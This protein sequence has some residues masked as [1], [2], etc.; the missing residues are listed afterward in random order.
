MKTFIKTLI[1]SFAAVAM[2]F[3][4]VALAAGLNDDP[5]DHYVFEATNKSGTNGA[6]NNWSRTVTAGDNDLIS[7][8]IY[9]HATAGSINDV[10]FKMEDL[11]GREFAAGSQE[12]VNGQVSASNAGTSAG[13]SKI[14]FTDD[15]TLRLYNVS[16]QPNQCT[17]VTCERPF[18][19]S[20][21]SV[22]SSGINVGTIQEGWAN[23][24]NMVVT[25]KA[26]PTVVTPTYDDCTV[27]G[28]TVAHGASRNFYST[29][30]VAYGQT[31]SAF[32]QT[33]TCND[34]TMSGSTSY[35][36]TSCTVG[37]APVFVDPVVDTNNPTN[38]DEDSATLQGDVDFSADVDSGIVFFEW[39]T[40]SSN[41]YNDTSDQA[42]SSDS[43]FSA[44]ITGLNDNTRYYYR[45]V[46]EGDNGQTYYGPIK[47]FTTDA[48]APAGT[49]V[50]IDTRTESSVQ[51]DSARLNGRL[52]SGD[53]NEVWFAFSGTD[54]TPSC[55]SSAQRV[56]VSGTYDSG[57]S[58]SKTVTGLDANEKYYF[59]AC[60][61]D[62][63][64][65]VL[66]GDIEDFTTDEDEPNNP[67]EDDAEVTTFTPSS[68]DEDSAKLNGRVD[69]GDNSD[70]WFAFSRIDSTPACSAGSQRINVSGSYDKNDSFS[71]TVTGLSPNTKY[72]YRACILGDNGDIESG[73]IRSFVTDE[74][75]DGPTVPTPPTV[76]PVT[77][78]RIPSGVTT[79]QATLR[80]FVSGDG[81]G[82]C[83]FQYGTSTG[84]GLTTPAQTVNLDNTGECTSTRFNLQPN[85]T[86]YYRSV[87]V[88]GGQTYYGLRQSFR[89]GSAPVVT[90]PPVVTTPRVPRTP[91]ITTPRIPIVTDNTVTVTVV[92]EVEQVVGGLELT[93]FV[94]SF[95][96][97]RFSDET[98]ADRDEA[99]FYKVLVRNNT[100]EVLEDLTVVDYIPFALELDGQRALNDDSDKEVRWRIAQLQ[101]GETREFTTEMRVREDVRY[102]S[103]IDSFA[104]IFNDDVSVN[105]NE[106]FIDVEADRVAAATTDSEGSQA[107]SVFGAG[108]L[109]AT[110]A[111]WAILSLI[112]LAIA[113]LVSRI[114]FARN[115][116]ERVLA[117]LRAMQQNV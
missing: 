38:V 61:L 12:T 67:T 98:E 89:T 96:D 99:V 45:A 113:F 106:V 104:T 60:T 84:Y 52:I 7:F 23:Q 2:T 72:Y 46:L 42:R 50:E 80:S 71:K 34:G 68:I 26:I 36:Y 35:K 41:L 1:V 21:T 82:T 116:N 65:D 55:T 33:R 3:G 69:E 53:N 87:L 15:V 10:T 62:N 44:N 4:S 22:L 83:Y 8:A 6:A 39:G 112:V 14:M 40:S 49:D 77:V 95:D 81:A 85:T 48:D 115:E 110:L 102:G 101:P 57:E 63:D 64:G 90:N 24:G 9:Y 73:S 75:E 74:D 37:S 88:D 78:T 105:S 91:I 11:R 29:T 92:E 117:E 108:F 58:F 32:D 76:D 17:S 86:Y 70:V 114:L 94:S 20:A 93:K 25:F 56:S 31:C 66:S 19:G 103:V 111:G 97:P 28:V 47:N 79:N 109:P 30:E 54:S 5:L 27:N 107:A 51:D 100:T 16:W 59:R 43:N 18:S 13:T